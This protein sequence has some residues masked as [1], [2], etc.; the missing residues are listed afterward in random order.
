MEAA[1]SSEKLLISLVEAAKRLSISE[2]TLWNLRQS[3]E[4]RVVKIGRS[5]RVA[6]DDLRGLVER[7]RGGNG[8]H[9]E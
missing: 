6:V 3:G 9:L 1:E 4:L 2:R 8:Q 7:R 5:V